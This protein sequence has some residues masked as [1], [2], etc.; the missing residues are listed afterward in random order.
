M[1]YLGI[2]SPYG[3]VLCQEILYLLTLWIFNRYGQPV[4][5][6]TITRI[7]LLFLLIEPGGTA[8][9]KLFLSETLFL[10]FITLALL[11]IGHYVKKEYFR[12]IL[13]S[14]VIFGLGVLIRPSLLYL[15]IFISLTLI[16]FNFH[17][18]KRWLHS[19]LFLLIITLT[20]TP[21]IIRNFH[22]SDSIFISGQQSNVLANYHV[23]YVWESA[24]G[25]PFRE[26]QKIIAT[27]VNAA[28]K[29]QE[30]FKEL[31]LSKIERYK[32]Q[33]D[34]AFN[35]LK[36]YPLEYSERWLV[37]ISK[38]MFGINLTVLNLA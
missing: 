37:G 10:P 22:H 36:K 31:P 32:V 12:Y 13:L 23:P 1:G 21:W 8:Y 27:K 9:P 5:G 20:V 28:V 3:V 29:K 18:T 33:Q 24:K 11:L 2:N 15:P 4:F 7:G 19:G 25:I 34:I 14:G 6:R 38:A 16:A 26:G 30:K 35:E 17:S